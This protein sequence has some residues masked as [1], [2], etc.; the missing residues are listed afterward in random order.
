MPCNP[1]IGYFYE[2]INYGGRRAPIFGNNSWIGNCQNDKY[3]SVKLLPGY[4]V[5]MYQHIGYGGCSYVCTGDMPDFTRIGWNDIVSSYRVCKIIGYFYEHVNYQ[6]RRA[7]VYD[8]NA[9]VGYCQNDKYSSVKVF[10]GY[11]IRMYEHS[12]YRGRSYLCRGDIPNFCC[13]G[14][15]DI[16]SSYKCVRL[17]GYFYEHIN[18]GGRRFP[19]YEDCNWI[20]HC[21]NDKFSS[22]KIE[23]GYRLKMYEH[24]N[25]GGCRYETTRS[26]PNFCCIG[27]ND[28]VSS[29]KVVSA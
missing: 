14:W 7:P 19:I 21:A 9:W 17:L 1:C 13:L 15:N 27:W 29:F 28:K 18:Y 8:D 26:I 4:N 22:C 12:C 3:S 2:H 20:G 23:P 16:V 10:H 6:G 24:I 25:F 5:R 11:H